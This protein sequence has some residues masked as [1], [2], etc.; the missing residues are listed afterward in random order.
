MDNKQH[1]PLVVYEP[2]DLV[3]MLKLSRATINDMLNNGELP[4]VVIRSGARKKTFRIYGD[5]LERWLKNN[6]TKAAAR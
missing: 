3:P 4:A 1:H 2:K 6:E 5:A